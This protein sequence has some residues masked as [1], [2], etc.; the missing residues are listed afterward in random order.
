[1]MRISISSIVR[2]RDLFSRDTFK[3]VPYDNMS[4]YHL[5]S[6]VKGTNGD[7]IPRNSNA[8]LL[9]KWLEE[10]VLPCIDKGYLDSFKFFVYVLE[11]DIESSK[12]IL[13]VYDFTIKY[14]LEGRPLTLNGSRLE[15]KED[16]RDQAKRFIRAL[17]AFT[18][19]LDKLP[20]TRNISFSLVFNESTPDDYIPP[21]FVEDYNEFSATVTGKKV[22][23]NIDGVQTSA[24]SF[25]IEFSA[26]DEAL[27]NEPENPYHPMASIQ[28]EE[29]PSKLKRCQSD[30]D[31]LSQDTKKSK[32]GSIDVADSDQDF[33]ESYSTD[34]LSDMTPIDQI[35]AINKIDKINTNAPIKKTILTKSLLPLKSKP[36][37]YGL[38]ALSIKPK[39]AKGPV[40]SC[41]AADSF[42]D[43][44]EGL[45]QQDA[46]TLPSSNY[47]AHVSLGKYSIAK[48]PILLKKGENDFAMSQSQ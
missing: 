2:M 42:E 12:K 24:C 45:S 46:E 9:M 19:T 37:R 47:G 3:E 36:L 29:Q 41:M 14:D 22:C 10:G 39:G 18:S 13:E 48:L 6:A 8:F 23:Q 32:I 35:I 21:Y 25:N 17:V 11:G 33:I 26:L 30:S 4:I 31:P 34:S 15:S 44:L 5:E 27:F 7:L 28:V 40:N 20:D 16:L 38:N 43:T 1:M